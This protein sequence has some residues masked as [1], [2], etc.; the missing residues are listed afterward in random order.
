MISASS[1]W[2]SLEIAKLAVGFLTPIL[3][4]TLGLVVTRAAR[5]IKN[6]QWASRKLI[7]RRIELHKEMA[8]KLND[9]YCFFATVGHFRDIIPPD[10]LKAKRELDKLFFQNEQLFSSEFSNLTGWI[11][12]PHLRC[13]ASLRRFRRFRTA[14]DVPRLRTAAQPSGGC[15]DGRETGCLGCG[16][17][18]AGRS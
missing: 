9:L 12:V 17:G 1:P 18:A 11:C 3:L 6:A 14:G 16:G 7:E 10:A 15:A 5:R 8:P 2:N 13:A 4:F